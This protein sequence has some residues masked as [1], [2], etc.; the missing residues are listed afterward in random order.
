MPN[1]IEIVERILKQLDGVLFRNA[2]PKV[3]NLLPRQ[4]PG[5]VLVLHKFLKVIVVDFLFPVIEFRRSRIAPDVDLALVT[6]L[7]DGGTKEVEC[8]F[9]VS[10]VGSEA[11]F[12]SYSRAFDPI[13]S[14]DNILESMVGFGAHAKGLFEGWCTQRD[15]KEFLRGEV[16]AGV[17]T[18]IDDI[19]AGDRHYHLGTSCEAVQKFVERF[20]LAGS[21]RPTG[22]HGNPQNGVGSQLGLVWSTIEFAHGIVE[23]G[24]IVRTHSLEGR[25]DEFLNVGTGLFDSFAEVAGGITVPHL[26]GLLVAGGGPAW[27]GSKVKATI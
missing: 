6:C 9:H 22:S 25:E 12:I 17:D 23:L 8:L 27:D 2:G 10:N 16:V 5:R 26:M 15:E 7:G 4:A 18:S 21:P 11:T 13:F 3:D 14:L 24:N 20:T 19:K 1:K